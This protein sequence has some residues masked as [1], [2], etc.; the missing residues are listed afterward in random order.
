MS[1]STQL[2]EMGE[3]VDYMEKLHREI[4]YYVI[5]RRGDGKLC[6]SRRGNPILCDKP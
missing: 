4:Q 3:T 2:F 5:N 1:V 6:D